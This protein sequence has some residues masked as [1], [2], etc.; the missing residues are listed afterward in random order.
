[1]KSYHAFKKQLVTITSGQFF[2]M[3]HNKG[4]I[5][6][7]IAQMMTS[8]EDAMYQEQWDEED[9]DID[10]TNTEDSPNGDETDDDEEVKR[11]SVTKSQRN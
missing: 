7:Y 4:N 5:L 2:I 11:D 8:M 3:P 1:M 6:L 10:N 9:T